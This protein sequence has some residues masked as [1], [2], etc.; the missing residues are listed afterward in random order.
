MRRRQVLALWAVGLANKWRGCDAWAPA[1]HE[2]ILRISNHLLK[3]RKND[4]V[5]HLLH[6]DII[7]IASWEQEM[8]SK[9]PET[10]ALHWHRQDLTGKSTEWS[11]ASLSKAADVGH[12]QCDANGVQGSLFCALA[13]FFEHFA[14]DALL[15]EFPKP[16]EPINTPQALAALGKFKP[17]DLG[18]TEYLKWMM[19]LLGD[20]HQPLH[21]MR[22]Y[23]YGRDL[24]VRFKGD[25]FTLLA[26]WEEVIPKHLPALVF[27][28]AMD[29]QYQERAPKWWDKMPT[30]LFRDWAKETA[31]TVC[32]QVYS[33]MEEVG[34][35]GTL[36]INNPFE[37]SEELFNRWVQLA[38]DFVT[39]AGQRTA[40]ILSD[41]LEHRRHKS[42]A[43]DGRGHHGFRKTRWTS[44]L[45]KNVFIASV[46]VPVWVLA[47]RW[48]ERAGSASILRLFREH[49]KV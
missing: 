35:H 7:G 9:H 37:V 16:K 29:K 34:P 48:H 10:D 36:R 24:K 25:E 26:F 1:A 45:L 30:E 12:I 6:G 47:L 4:Q 43:K 3:G 38:N 2:R 18:K 31:E 22:Q 46:V 13:F 15:K 20:L 21:W 11:C 23:G 17:Q 44:N 40:F 8:T 32:G 19:L 28:K 42:A 39:L 41:I 14:H 5:R 33:A 49:L 27:N